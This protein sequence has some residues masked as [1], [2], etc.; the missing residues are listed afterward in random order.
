MF[1]IFGT[2]QISRDVKD[3]LPIR[4]VCPRCS[5][6]SDMRL[7]RVATYLSVFFVCFAVFLLWFTTVLNAQDL[8]SENPPDTVY[9]SVAVTDQQH[10]SVRGLPK[11]NFR[12]YEDK[13][14]QTI[15]S[16]SQ[17]AV[18]MSLGIIW[19]VSSSMRTEQIF[20]RAKAAVTSLL[21]F[22]QTENEYFL[23]TFSES[24][25]IQPITN[26]RLQ[27]EVQIDTK[28][29]RTALFDAIY[30]GLDRI[31]Q[32]KHDKKVLLII[33][34]G[35]ENCSK[36]KASEIHKYAKESDVQIYGILPPGPMWDGINTLQ[37]IV[38]VTGG[39]I[40][41]YKDD[42]SLAA[43]LLL[44]EFQS[45]YQICYTPAYN[46]HDG[47]WRKIKIKLFPP[48]GHPKLIIHARQGR[49]AP[50]N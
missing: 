49:Y 34:D 24:A 5:M 31:N 6:L 42:W 15:T 45:Q 21:S 28:K 10:H 9:M 27:T 12:I 38:S 22:R 13:K 16:F 47:K 11:E 23:V 17:E 40:F 4:N 50:K 44:E 18:P 8:K 46:K 29:G 37:S 32:S 20:E 25:R 1:I 36:H 2:R 7:Q 43:Q 3:S 19:D 30:L 35:E 14:E 33:S 41:F 48:S 39:R 26:E